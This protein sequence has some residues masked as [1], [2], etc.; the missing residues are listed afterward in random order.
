MKGL[1]LIAIFF[2]LLSFA[3]KEGG[4]GGGAWVCREKDQSIRWARLIDFF[5]ATE[6]FHLDLKKSEPGLDANDIFDVLTEKIFQL[7]QNL[8][9]KLIPYFTKVSLKT[10]YVSKKLPVINDAHPRLKPMA[11]DCENGS[12][13]YEQVAIFTKSG[14]VL[15]NYDLF[16]HSNFSEHD[17]AGLCLHEV[18]YAYMRDHFQ[19]KDSVR[20]RKIVGLLSSN[21]PPKQIKSEL[22]LLLPTKK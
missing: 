14:T 16:F 3:N 8:H 11:K 15:I 13:S 10:S 17:K 21:L 2:P 22:S 20:S 7:D 4:N 12:I 1:L 9:E 18:I 5:E 6:E 19:D